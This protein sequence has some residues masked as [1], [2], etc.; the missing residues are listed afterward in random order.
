[1]R[2]QISVLRHLLGLLFIAFA[3]FLGYIA[4]P[5]YEQPL[6]YRGGVLVTGLF[7]FVIGFCIVPKTKRRSGGDLS[8]SVT[9]ETSK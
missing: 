8:D 9:K 5:V 6:Q 7:L 3:I 1:M 2:S 4:L